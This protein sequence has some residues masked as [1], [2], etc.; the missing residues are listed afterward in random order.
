MQRLR[1]ELQIYD[2]QYRQRLSK[3]WEHSYSKEGFDH[4]EHIYGDD[5][6]TYGYEL[7]RRKSFKVRPL[8]SVDLDALVDPLQQL[9]DRHQQIAGLQEQIVQ[10]QHQLSAAHQALERPPLPALAAPTGQWPPHNSPEA[11]LSHLY[12]A[13]SQQRFQELLDQVSGLQNIPHAGEVAYLEGL[14]R[15]A[16]DQQELA[17]R[18]FEAA[19][20]R[21]F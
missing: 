15:S 6:K 1:Q 10:L 11:G 7:P 9:R 20:A 2:Q 3:R 17:L 14:A 18:C 5:L 16:L 4:L 21:T 19:Q 12:D 13:L 8:A